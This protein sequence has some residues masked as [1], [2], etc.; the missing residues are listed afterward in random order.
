MVIKEILSEVA[1]G[2][3]RSSAVSQPAN[4]KGNTVN[5]GLP[6]LPTRSFLIHVLRTPKCMN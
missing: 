5:K 2:F 3:L 4:S 6:E 1:V